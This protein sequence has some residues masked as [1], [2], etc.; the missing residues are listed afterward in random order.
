MT[1]Q[2]LPSA[3]SSGEQNVLTG[4][5]LYVD[6]ARRVPQVD[7]RRRLQ[8]PV[9]VLLILALSLGS[10]LGIAALGSWLFR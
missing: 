3:A 8:W 5:H 2:P 7:G 10:W 1:S 4:A 6:V 9:A